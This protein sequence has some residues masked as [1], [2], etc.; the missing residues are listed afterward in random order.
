MFNGEGIDMM[1]EKE[2]DYDLFSNPESIAKL[3]VREQ[4]VK[5]L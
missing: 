1:S 4:M 5:F 2:E 3:N